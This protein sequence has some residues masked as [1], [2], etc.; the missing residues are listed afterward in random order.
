LQIDKQP[1]KNVAS[2]AE[3]EEFKVLL[4]N[5][6]YYLNIVMYITYTNAVF[7]LGELLKFYFSN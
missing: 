6:G 1:Y 7:P 3:I 2:E 5:A 4:S